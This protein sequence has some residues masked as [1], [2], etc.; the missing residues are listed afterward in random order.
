MGTWGSGNFQSDT[1]LDHL[2]TVVQP[3]FTQI[4]QAFKNK[5]SLEPDEY[6][7]TAALCNMD[8]LVAIAYGLGSQ[9]SP[10]FISKFPQVKT[11]ESWQKIYLE[12][13]DETIDGLDPDEDYKLER[14]DV[15]V[16]TFERFIALAKQY[17]EVS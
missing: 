3:L 5:V 4:S 14:R 17:Q 12:V 10:F 13:W 2:G 8:I 6:D 9:K 11:I 16:K 15:I 7:G 1:A